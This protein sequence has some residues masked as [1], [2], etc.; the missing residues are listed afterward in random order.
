MLTNTITSEIID[1]HQ[2]PDSSAAIAPASVPSASVPSVSSSSSVSRFRRSSY[3][4]RLPTDIEL[5]Y[6]SSVLYCHRSILIDRSVVFAAMFQDPDSKDIDI[7]LQVTPSGSAISESDFECLF[8]LLYFPREFLIQAIVQREWTDNQLE[9]LLHLCHYFGLVSECRLLFLP[10]VQ[11]CPHDLKT[12]FWQ[13]IFWAETN[14]IPEVLNEL[15]AHGGKYHRF[16]Q[17]DSYTGGASSIGSGNGRS[18][19]SAETQYE[20]LRAQNVSLKEQ[21]S[22][23]QE[24][25]EAGWNGRMYTVRNLYG[26]P[27]PAQQDIY[28]ALKLRIEL[29]AETMKKKR[30]EELLSE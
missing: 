25:Y 2:S 16:Y 24:Y 7:P 15:I 21:I 27:N 18:K 26:Q 1:Q 11:R 20:L 28:Q 10:L 17:V 3:P 23:M 5:H 29:L 8:E 6:G 14:R 12:R 13:M 22:E 9:S 19:L 4:L 30:N